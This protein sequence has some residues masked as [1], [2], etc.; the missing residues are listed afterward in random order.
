M[1][2]C[3]RYGSVVLLEEGDSAEKFA[4]ICSAMASLEM[5]TVVIW[6]PVFYRKG[7]WDVEVQRTFLRTAAEYDLGA[8]V[9]LTGQVSDLEDR[10]EE[11]RSEAQSLTNLASRTLLE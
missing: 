5:N 9:E 11:L 6:P 7:K 8:I 1:F 4:G 3:F 2:D 10:S